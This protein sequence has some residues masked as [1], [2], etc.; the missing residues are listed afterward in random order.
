MILASVFTRRLRGFR[1]LD[2]L[3]LTVLLALA[4]GSYAFKTFAGAEGADT[5]GVQ[6]QIVEE[7]K[8]IRLLRAEIAHLEDPGRIERLSVRYL[9]L[10]PV[11]PRRETTAEA[12]PQIATRGDDTAKPGAR[13][14]GAKP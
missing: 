4:L 7:G 8:R 5:V 2:L 10:Q 13:K 14:P 1:V 9:G 3:A 12:L 11:D 6:D